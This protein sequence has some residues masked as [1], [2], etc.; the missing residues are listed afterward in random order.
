MEKNLKCLIL[1]GIAASGKSTWTIDFISKNPGWVR[2]NRDS[3][4]AMLRNE[5][6][7]LPKVEDGITEMCYNAIDVAFKKKLNVILDNTNL[8]SFYINDIIKY[9]EYRADIEFRVF[10]ISLDA[11]IERDKNREKSV[12]E[13]I[14]K[15]M[16]KD[17]NKLMDSFSYINQTKKEFIYTDPVWDNTLPNIVIFDIDGTLA[18][19][20][21]KRGPF[22]WHDVFKDDLDKVVF[23]SYLRHKHYGDRIFIVS[24][25]DEAARKPTEEW[26]AFHG[27]N[28]EKLLMRKA[29]DFRKDTIVKTE[30]YNEHIKGKYNVINVFDDRTQ[31]VE[32]TWRA[33]GLKCYQV[34][35]GDF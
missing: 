13:T 23:E 34:E 27:I 1:I 31:V 30:I 20:N 12:G 8:K 26:L 17:Y 21:G 32:G 2:I 6:Q 11:A 10:D 28:Y 14:I 35:K 25:R 18:H 3:F 16:Y 9:V 5:Q 19:M 15:R 22:D 33:L 4:R 24:G 29:D 7:C